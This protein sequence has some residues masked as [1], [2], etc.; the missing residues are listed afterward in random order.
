MRMIRRP[1]TVRSARDG[2]ATDNSEAARIVLADIARYGGEQAGLVIWA[3]LIGAKAQ[4]T[5]VGPLFAAT[6]RRAA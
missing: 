2:F 5:I 1:P 3:R 4:P 6:G